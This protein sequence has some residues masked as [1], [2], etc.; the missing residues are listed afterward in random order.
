LLNDFINT[1]CE[2]SLWCVPG[3]SHRTL[4]VA[5]NMWAILAGNPRFERVPASIAHMFPAT[6]SAARSDLGVVFAS[7]GHKKTVGDRLR[8]GWLNR[9]SFIT[10][11][12]EGYHESRRCSRDT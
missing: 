8:V 5:R 10:S 12:G 2:I 3:N 9:F 6:R 1:F 4:N 11:T 7:A